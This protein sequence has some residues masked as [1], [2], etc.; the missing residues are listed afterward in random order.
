MQVLICDDHPIV[1]S[2][3]GMTLETAFDAQVHIALSCSQALGKVRE[4]GQLD[5]LMLDLHI[6]GEDPRGNLAAARAA[7]PG[8]PIMV[9][10]GS[11]D[12]HNLRLA[13][14]MDVAGFLPKSSSPEVVEAALRLVLAGGRYLPDAVRLLALG[15]PVPTPTPAPAPTLAGAQVVSAH[16]T[17]NATAN[18]GADGHAGLTTRQRHVLQLLAQGSPNKQIARELGISPATVKVHVAQVLATLGAGN[19]TEA[20][21]MAHQRGLL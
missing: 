15:E 18:G 16:A 9:F 7:C 17:A 12:A 11:D 6:P 14:E 1:A 13:L 10:S 4:I 8:T 5:L 21:M 2:A 20:V 3:L 19:R